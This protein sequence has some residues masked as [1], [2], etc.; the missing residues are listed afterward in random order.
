MKCGEGWTHG[1]EAFL[2]SI[3]V[4]SSSARSLS[5]SFVCIT[6]SLFLPS[7]LPTCEQKAT[8]ADS[9]TTAATPTASSSDGLST[10]A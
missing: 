7:Y 6:H 3:A 9:S 4:V 8:T 5:I 2:R 10:A 1:S